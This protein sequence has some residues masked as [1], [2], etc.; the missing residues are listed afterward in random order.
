MS[1]GPTPVPAVPAPP[2]A[3]IAARTVAGARLQLELLDPGSVDLFRL[4]KWPG[5]DWDETLAIYRNERVDPPVGHKDDFAVLYLGT[6]LPGVAMECRI[7]RGDWQDKLTW[8][9]TLA[10]D[11]QVARYA[12][13]RPAI[14]VP[15]DGPNR[16]PL[17]LDPGR[18]KLGSKAPFQEVALALFE[19]FGR[20]VHGMSWESEHRNQPARIYALWHHHKSTIGLSTVP[21]DRKYS[22]LPDDPDWKAF[23]A[24]SPDVEGLDVS[25]PPPP[26]AAAA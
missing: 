24:D 13:S 22:R 4:F 10:A 5:A 12:F 8:I 23:L 26:A 20:V 3:P 21:A 14:F 2:A 11:Y 9:R 16:R 1:G 25:P 7:L 15:I 18:R 6:T 17:G 19:R